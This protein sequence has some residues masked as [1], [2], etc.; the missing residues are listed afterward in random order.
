MLKKL[1]KNKASDPGGLINELFRPEVIG[2]DLKESIFL[3]LKKVK[4]NLEIPEIMENANITSI[5][6]SKGDKNDLKN[7]RGIFS[8]NIFRSLLLKLIYNDEYFTID[9]N[10]S[11]SNVGGRKHKN[12]RNHIF[13]VN[14]IINEALKKKENVDIEILDYRQCFDGMWLDETI[15]D[16]FE[17]GLVNDNLNL[18][19]KL[20]EKNRVAIVTPYGLSERVEIKKIVM[21]GEN[22][23]PLECS[24]QVDSY[25]R[26]C[27]EEDKYLFKYRD[28]VKVPPLSMVDD[29]LSISKCGKESVLVNAF[30][31]V[32]TNIKKL[33]YGEDKCFKM[34][35]GQDKTI[36]PDLLID[37]WKT[38][39]TEKVNTG[40]SSITDV[41][42]GKHLISEK[43][44]EK[45]LGDVIDS[46]GKMNSNIEN[47]VNKGMGKLNRLWTILKTFASENITLL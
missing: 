28:A 8:V 11:D 26:E 46:K 44:R 7:D 23:A 39:D 3:L 18:I 2:D 47:R 24:V 27:M 40:E 15:N 41:Y 30:L 16:L 10:M 38:V 42:G 21:Q 17:A 9:S 35:V 4:D 22:L 12:I 45:Y 13:I 33:Q 5:Y 36:C 32:K 31:N 34:H 6:K 20:N 25:G 43:I 37:K 1:K 19:Y 29:L 14:G